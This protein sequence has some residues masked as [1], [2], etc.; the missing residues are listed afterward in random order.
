MRA[1]GTGVQ[2][3]REQAGRGSGDGFSKVPS[4][5]LQEGQWKTAFIGAE[6]GAAIGT[7]P[8]PSRKTYRD[9]PSADQSGIPITGNAKAKAASRSA[10]SALRKTS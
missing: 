2:P 4:G 5:A 9:F 3:Q 10:V 7:G 1:L 6:V 8:G